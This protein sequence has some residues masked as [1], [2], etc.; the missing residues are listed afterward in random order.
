M[1]QEDLVRDLEIE[2]SETDSDDTGYTRAVVSSDDPR[3]LVRIQVIMPRTNV[4]DNHAVRTECIAVALLIKEV[5]REVRAAR[6]LLQD[7]TDFAPQAQEL[8]NHHVWLRDQRHIIEADLVVV[9]ANAGS[10]GV[11]IETQLSASGTIL[12]LLIHHA[13]AEVSQVLLSRL[14]PTFE[15]IRYRSLEELRLQLRDRS[16]S[17][18][19][20]V[21]ASKIQ[22]R[23]VLEQIRRGQIGRSVFAQ[24]LRQHIS[25]AE[26]SERT[27]IPVFELEYL[28]RDD[29][30]VAL[31]SLI[32]IQRLARALGLDFFVGNDGTPSLSH[33]DDHVDGREQCAAIRESIDNYYDALRD[34]RV[35]LSDEI[36][37]DCW[38]GYAVELES[39]E[40]RGPKSPSGS[41]A[42]DVR[43]PVFSK[44]RWTQILLECRRK[45]DDSGPGLFPPTNA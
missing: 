3:P 18:V 43:W 4:R 31:M 44:A 14:S 34:D 38:K 26:L 13:D 40:K 27:D 25:F 6:V 35:W 29:R 41:R 7:P 16:S 42:A 2:W 19:E 1:A 32:Q 23:K 30:Y 5:F 36:V 9:V 33:Q 21:L 45:S 17:I 20:Q 15:P 8:S 11:G 10:C 12:R 24:R 28:E 22:R 39:I 37:F